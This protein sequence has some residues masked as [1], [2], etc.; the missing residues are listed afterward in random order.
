MNKHDEFK[1]LLLSTTYDNFCDSTT[2]EAHLT[3]LR[4]WIK[5]NLPKKLFRYRSYNSKNVE[6]LRNDEI[7]GSIVTE[8]NDPYEYI[9]CY[10]L[11]KINELLQHEFDVDV[12]VKHISDIKSG[13]VPQQ[14]RTMLDDNIV[15][16]L[17]QRIKETDD[18]A[19]I[20]KALV[21]FKPVV[22]RFLQEKYNSII[23]DFFLSITTAEIQYNIACF[24]EDNTSS[25]MWGHYADS[26][27]GF[28]LEYDFTETIVDCNKSCNDIKGCNKFLLG[29]PI[30]PICYS[31]KRF[32]ATA[33]VLSI[34]Q[35]VLANEA[36]ID[37]K[38]HFSDVLLVVKCLLTKSD[39]WN[40]EK[41]WRLFNWY[42][43]DIKPHRP[44]VKLKTKAIYLGNCME[45]K[46]K[47]E[48]LLIAKEKEI[49]CYQVIPK[50]FLS[51]FSYL[52]VLIF[53]GK[54]QVA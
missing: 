5:M 21:L 47:D 41:E 32:D 33:G 20:T 25:L 17:V 49:P 13:F 7:W 12:V 52:P 38:N 3:V 16:Q 6:A 46:H 31:E 28:C 2:A 19:A 18:L 44:I 22:M 45:Q 29:I 48:L 4:D 15:T 11:D 51:E 23:N 35:Q 39:E 54:N 24:S 43:N 34:I 30:A 27:K 10:D 36:K 9:P 50:Y 8:D 53:D 14:L 40:Y 1:S 26:H 37:M 42:P